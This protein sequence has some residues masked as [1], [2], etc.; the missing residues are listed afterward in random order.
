MNREL[1]PSIGNLVFGFNLH[2]RCSCEYLT[3][4]L[5]GRCLMITWAAPNLI[6]LL[7]MND[8]ITHNLWPRQAISNTGPIMAITGLPC[9]QE[10]PATAET[11]CRV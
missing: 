1:W 3:T 9:P 2:F 5:G 10:S 7:E 6:H 11:G 4:W 8:A